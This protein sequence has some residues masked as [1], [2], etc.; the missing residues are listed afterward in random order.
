M[1]DDIKYGRLTIH[2]EA[3]LPH[4]LKDYYEALLTRLHVGDEAQMLTDVLCVLLAALEPLSSAQLMQVLVPLYC[5]SD[6]PSRLL[7]NALQLARPLLHARATQGGGTGWTLYHGALRE[8]LHR[9]PNVRNARMR[10]QNLISLWCARWSEHKEPYAVRNYARHLAADGEWDELRQ[11]LLPKDGQ[12]PWAE[13]RYAQEDAYTGYIGDL[14]LL[15]QRALETKDVALLIESHLMQVSSASISYLPPVLLAYLVDVGT[16]EG[17]WPT[18]R[19]LAYLSQMPLQRQ[20]AALEALAALGDDEVCSRLMAYAQGLSDPK[21]RERVR[22]LIDRACRGNV[23]SPVEAGDEHTRELAAGVEESSIT[24]DNGFTEIPSVRILIDDIRDEALRHRLREIRDIEDRELRLDALA[25]I[26]PQIQAISTDLGV[27]ASCDQILTRLSIAYQDRVRQ[28]L[29]LLPLLAGAEREELICKALALAR[30]IPNYPSIPFIIVDWDGSSDGVFESNIQG[31]RAETL[32]WILPY[33]P[34]EHREQVLGEIGSAAKQL[35]EEPERTSRSLRIG[36]GYYERSDIRQMALLQLLA[37][38]PK[39]NQPDIVDLV[40]QVQRSD[41]REDRALALVALLPFASTDVQPLAVKAAKSLPWADVK[42]RV[43]SQMVAHLS[44]NLRAEIREDALGIKWPTERLEVLTSLIPHLHG[45]ERA[46]AMTAGV[47]AVESLEGQREQAKVLARLA[48]VAD[49]TQQFVELYERALEL[50]YDY[51]PCEAANMV[52]DFAP[53]LPKVCFGR[54]LDTMMEWSDASDDDFSLALDSMAPH[55]PEELLPTGL[56]LARHIAFS[57]LRAT[58][59]ESFL[60]RLPP[61]DQLPLAL[62]A[63]G[64]GLSIT[65]PERRMALLLR[66]APFCGEVLDNEVSTVLSQGSGVE[67][68][69]TRSWLRSQS[70]ATKQ[71]ACE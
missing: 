30:K 12:V 45:Q 58:T 26:V 69:N 11:L 37:C 60:P 65:E 59:L 22:E 3:I 49:N 16:T 1:I 40:L 47:T 57:P 32:A 18:D 8:H 48:Q 35:A 7:Q 19:A 53:R 33:L 13:T 28:L 56:A 14:K 15:G 71:R 42:A 21:D 50:A 64:A 55:M 44:H 67:I 68:R 20:T 43:F 38:L 63:L 2:D 24:A 31:S 66:I 62:E 46:Q 23:D 4:G 36:L 54:I 70:Q 27:L 41:I 34:V 9:A 6:D 25:V 17:R 51:E 10:A 39:E 29:D 5:Y 52:A 61:D